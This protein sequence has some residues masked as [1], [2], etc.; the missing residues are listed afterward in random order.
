[1]QHRIPAEW[2]LCLYHR[3]NLQTHNIEDIITVITRSRCQ[4]S[5]YYRSLK[6]ECCGL[7]R[8]DFYLSFILRIN[9]TSQQLKMSDYN[10]SYKHGFKRNQHQFITHSYKTHF[11]QCCLYYHNPHNHFMQLISQKL[12]PYASCVPSCLLQL[13]CQTIKTLTVIEMY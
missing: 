1:M 3:S 12:L 8:E 7:L 6:C 4:V 11:M 13:H 10:L 9:D 5:S 2:I